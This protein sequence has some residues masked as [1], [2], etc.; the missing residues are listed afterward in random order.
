M[1]LLRHLGLYLAASAHLAEFLF[2]FEASLLKP[3]LV[4]FYMHEPC[5]PE[6]LSDAASEENLQIFGLYSVLLDR[7]CGKKFLSS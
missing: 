1:S 7:I 2:C 3:A 4:S 6:D 5:A